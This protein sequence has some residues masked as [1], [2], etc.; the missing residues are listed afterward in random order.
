M[1][2]V[3]GSLYRRLQTLCCCL[4]I[5][6][7]QHLLQNEMPTCRGASAAECG[8]CHAAGYGQP[9][10]STAI[11]SGPQND[12]ISAVVGTPQAV[13]KWRMNAFILKRFIGIYQTP[14]NKFYVKGPFGKRNG[15]VRL[16]RTYDSM[17]DAAKVYDRAM[18][19]R[20]GTNTDVKLNFPAEALL[21]DGSSA[22]LLAA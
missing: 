14:G 20:F 10:P 19:E 4:A 12:A 7:K 21:Q 9:V 8:T 2:Q 6:Q 3:M 16:Q 13:Y 17:L 18:L 22:P 15:I 11:T 1:L 5:Q